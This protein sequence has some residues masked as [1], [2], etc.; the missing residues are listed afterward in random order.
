MNLLDMY[1]QG[2]CVG[3]YGEIERMG[4]NALAK[5]NIG[6]VEA[7]LRETMNRVAYNLRIIYTGLVGENYCFKR[8]IRIDFDCPLLK[9]FPNV[10]DL[11]RKLEKSV[12]EFGHVP[13]SLKLFYEIVGSCNFAWDY[14]SIE[15]IP[16]EGADPIQI[17][18]ITDLLEEVEDMEVEDEDPGLSVS[19]DYLHKDNTSGGPGY[20]VELTRVPQPDSRF[21]NEEH[22]TSFINYL[23]IAM[24]GC[25]FSRA[26]AVSHMES[27]VL[28]SEK[29]RPL[30][31]PI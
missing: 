9:P 1:I 13:L 12:R 28:Y 23:R 4:P 26:G 5:P 20:A 31:K 27:F 11:I 2:D 3:V 7:V 21:L 22:E 14:D 10:K 17:G 8:N 29:I 25:G 6:S 16:R 30:L 15:E 19:A 24:D 18:S